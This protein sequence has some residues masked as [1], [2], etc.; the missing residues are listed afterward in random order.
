MGGVVRPN[1]LLFMPDQLRADGVGCFG[2]DVASTP[3]IDA[4]ASEGVRFEQA[5]AQHSVC[6]Q[7]RISMFTGW[8]PHTSGHR[9][10]TYLLRPGEPNVF[11]SLREHGYH[12]ALAGA[13]GDMFGEGVTEISASRWGFTTPPD[14][15]AVDDWHRQRFGDDHRLGGSF[16]GG[17]LEAGPD[18]T[19][20][21][22]LDEATIVT[23]VDWLTDGLPEPWCLL[24]PLVFPHP[25]FAITEPWYSMHDRRSMPSPIPPV[26]G[27]PRFQTEIR[28]RYRLDEL[29]PGDWREIMAV[30]HGMISRVDHQLGRVLRAVERAGQRERTVTCF[31]TDHGEYL[32]DF[33]LVEKWPSG[34][35]PCLLRNPLIVHDPNGSSGTTDAL[36]EMIDLTATLLDFAEVAAGYTHFGRSLRPMLVD[37][38]RR[39]R[40]AVFAEGGF[41]RSEGALLEPNSGGHYRHKGAIQHELPELVGK[42]AVVRTHDWTYVERLY[43]GAELY[44][45]QVDPFE[46][47][48]LVADQHDVELRLALDPVVDGLRRRLT[49]WML[50][51]SDV[52]PWEPD[53]RL[54]SVLRHEMRP[55]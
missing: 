41:L 19:E 52:F 6:T 20:P 28:R 22:D 46:I 5:F 24:I 17:L 34:L 51:T 8:Y 47:D 4:L 16:L 25:P 13:R 3:N 18:G 10:L 40:S 36:V 43:E 11:R 37:P 39:H 44:D 21:F 38:T 12:V 45:R 48:N 7:S 55:R 9:S 50:E 27:K 1:L 15:S 29:E 14:M 35:E 42:A 23:A 33:G 31:F 30:Y 32:G 53:A 54:E 49:T 2:S 26:A